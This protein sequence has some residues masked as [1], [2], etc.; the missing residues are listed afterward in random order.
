MKMKTDGIIFD[1]DGTILDTITDLSNS[2]NEALKT[3]GF[4]GHTEAEY[5]LI[6]G[7][8]FENLIRTSLP[9]AETFSAEKSYEETVKAVLNTFV[10]IYREHYMDFTAPYEG[11]HEMLRNLRDRGILLGVNSNKR[12]DYTAALIRKHFPDI[13]FAMVIGQRAD[14]PKKPDPAAA[15]LIADRMAEQLGKASREMLTIAYIGDSKVDMKTARNA[16]MISCGVTWGFRGEQE[17]FEN[18]A[19]HIFRR[20]EE[21]TAWALEETGK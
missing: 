11:I 3:Y 7:N 10:G 2:V 14:L 18:G 12:E 6:I 13:P 15:F 19:E 1:L 5:K 21:I 8:G 17:L 4:P 9:A 16:G 20:P